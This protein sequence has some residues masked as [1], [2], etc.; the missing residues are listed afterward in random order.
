[1]STS[2]FA[3]WTDQSRSGNRVILLRRGGHNRISSM[4]MQGEAEAAEQHLLRSDC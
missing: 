4:M 3:T 2:T 1:V